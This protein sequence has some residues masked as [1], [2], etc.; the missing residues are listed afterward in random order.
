MSDRDSG[1]GFVAGFI[2]GV[3]IGLGIAFVS[4]PRP[5]DEV[6]ELLREK[7]ADVGGRVREITGN[8]RKIYTRAWK[9]HKDQTKIR[10]YAND[11]E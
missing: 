5:G 10:P 11:Y 7:A 1:V 9:Q 8:R 2:L 6:R 4:A 3:T